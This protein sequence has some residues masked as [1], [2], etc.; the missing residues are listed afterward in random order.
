MKKW[1]LVIGGL[2]M[3]LCGR[4]Q[5]FE[6]ID[7]QE[8][9]QASVNQL[10]RIPLKIRNN[11]EKAQF[12]IIRKTRSDLSESQKGYFCLE[13]NCLEPAIV[14]FSK[15]VEPGETVNLSYTVECGLQSAQNSLKFEVFPKGSPSESI[16]QSVS[17]S[18]EEKIQRS[19]YQS[20]EI[21]IHDVYPNPAQDQAIIDYKINGDFSKARI[22]LQNVLGKPMGEYELP[23]S[24][25]R[26]KIQTDELPA[27]IYFY[28]LYLGQ[29]GV[30]TRKIMVRK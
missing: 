30:F 14:E 6:L 26:I 17:L 15:K 16:E 8:N 20:K 3:T 23:E 1:L 13:N 29:N 12:Y 25:T 5:N 24:D 22:V 9:F 10:V 19:L 4:A 2:F 7:K 27:G 28:T 11:T 21:T 18:V